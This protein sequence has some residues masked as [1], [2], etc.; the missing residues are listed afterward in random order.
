MIN[1][2][3]RV[4]LR[5]VFIGLS[6][7][8]LH[9]QAFSQSKAN[10]V[11]GIWADSN[12][13]AFTHSYAIFSVDEHG[14]LAMTHY[15]EYNGIPMVEKGIG[16]YSHGTLNYDAVVTKGI[17]GWSLKGQHVLTLSE[18][19]NTLRGYYK[20]EKGNSGPLVFKRFRP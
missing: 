12:S 10:P 17:P 4:Y 11:N 5:F 2:S 18:D 7:F 6:I 9:K 20:D 19:G 16:F 13:A 1:I 14:K 3:L 15:L 8:C